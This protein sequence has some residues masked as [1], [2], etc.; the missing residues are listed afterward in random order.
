ME[1]LTIR[2]ISKKMQ[3]I[4]EKHKEQYGIK[5][6][7]TAIESI[8]LAYDALEFSYEELEKDN[9]LTKKDML[10]YKKTVDELRFSANAIAKLWNGKIESGEL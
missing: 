6:N 4:I 7:T 1:T 5:T 9:M 10:S 2:N 3:E 8:I